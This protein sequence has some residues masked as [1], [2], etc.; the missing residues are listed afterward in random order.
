MSFH[1][2][3]RF[4]TP[5]SS[6]AVTFYM[7]LSVP[8]PSADIFSAARGHAETLFLTSDCQGAGA[9]QL[10]PAYDVIAV[11]QSRSRDLL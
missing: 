5:F 9:E 3:Q 6:I 8:E 4:F 11:S 1:R 2:A 10:N 7:L